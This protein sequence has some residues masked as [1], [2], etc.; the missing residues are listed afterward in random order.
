MEENSVGAVL[1]E[2]AR[3]HDQFQRAYATCCISSPA[4]CT[5]ITAL[6][7]N[8][9]MTLGSLADYLGLD[10]GWVS[11]TVESLS[12]RGFVLKNPGASDK[13]VVI[14]S[15]SENGNERLNEIDEQLNSLS[16]RII[17]RIPVDKK[18]EVQV[19][20][21]LLRSSLRDELNLPIP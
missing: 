13:R 8:G 1:R 9:P 10:K 3:L 2:V 17:N 19:V 12:V 5:I 14:I 20:L 4:Q 11:R 6:G 7:R 21:E 18:N 16:C 15:L